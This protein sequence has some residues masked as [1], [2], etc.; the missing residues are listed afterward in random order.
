MLRRHFL[1]FLA[2]IVPG[3]VAVKML[4]KPTSEDVWYNPNEDYPFPSREN[5]N[6]YT[7]TT[8]DNI[9][10]AFVREFQYHMEQAYKQRGIR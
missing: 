9:H 8:N 3:V 1:R 5:E 10:T 2:S 6:T 7:S 4:P